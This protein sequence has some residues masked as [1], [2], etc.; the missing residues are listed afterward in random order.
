MNFYHTRYASLSNEE[1]NNLYQ[2]DRW[3]S[4]SGEERLDA[5]KEL[6]NRVAYECGNTQC[7]ITLEKMNGAQYGYYYNGQIY[8]SGSC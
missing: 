4:F 3:M 1:V 8:K 7:E 5:L 2:L 6:E